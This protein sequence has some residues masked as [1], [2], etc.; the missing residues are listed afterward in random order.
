MRKN[1]CNY[2]DVDKCL[3]R[4]GFL[5]KAK[6]CET[7]NPCEKQC[8]D[9]IEQLQKKA[10]YCMK[11]GAYRSAPRRPKVQAEGEERPQ[12]TYHL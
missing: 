3:E 6:M 9:A 10:P 11:M 7:L 12:L 4:L 1:V 8:V 2:S 5:E